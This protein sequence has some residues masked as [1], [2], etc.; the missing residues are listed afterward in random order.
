VERRRRQR[1]PARRP[2]DKKKPFVKKPRRELRRQQQF[3]CP[4]CKEIHA[5]TDLCKR[6]NFCRGCC[7]AAGKCDV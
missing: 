4:Q 1:G 3:R 5:L 7:A 6:C 2:V